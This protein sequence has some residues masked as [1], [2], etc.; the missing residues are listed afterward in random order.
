M[1]AI[2]PPY[3]AAFADY[4]R[5][6]LGYKS[7]AEYYI[8]GGG[9][10]VPWDFGGRGQGYADV[11]E[12]LRQAFVKNPY[13]KAFI[14]SGYYDFATPYFATR[15]TLN[16]MNLD[17]SLRSNISLGY[18]EAGHM[19]YIDMKSLGRLREDVRKF[20]DQAGGR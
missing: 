5:G 4:I 8:L 19:M 12:A 17:P 20:L 3:T 2:R 7:D 10:K 6:E 1:A 13:L 9:I 16:H 14:A 18:Y 15:Y 11:S